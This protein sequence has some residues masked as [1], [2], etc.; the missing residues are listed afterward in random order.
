M[1]SSDDFLTSLLLSSLYRLDIQG[2]G[3]HQHLY[4]SFSLTNAKLTGVTQL[5]DKHLTQILWQ[6]A[7]LNLHWCYDSRLSGPRLSWCGAGL[8]LTCP[9]C[10]GAAV[11]S[12]KWI[13]ERS[14]TEGSSRSKRYVYPYNWGITQQEGKVR[15]K[16]RT[17]PYAQ[18]VNLRRGKKKWLLQVLQKQGW[19]RVQVNTT[20]AACLRHKKGCSLCW[21]QQKGE[22][23]KEGWDRGGGICQCWQIC[24]MRGGAWVWSLT[25]SVM[26]D[27]RSLLDSWL[28]GKKKRKK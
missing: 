10:T 7:L 13:T 2:T 22:E 21:K 5:W 17:A 11:K 9:C 12:T 3:W 18:D 1:V 15:R 23:T 4:F 28:C 19:D 14:R 8:S 26:L 24:T 27:D 16:E 25:P 20:L 6:S